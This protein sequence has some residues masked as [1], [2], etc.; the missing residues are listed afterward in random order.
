MKK[1]FYLFFIL[2]LINTSIFAQLKYSFSAST[3]TYT[4]LTEW[5]TFTWAAGTSLDENYTTPTPIGFTFVYNGVPFDSFQVSTNGFLRLGTGLTSAT[6][7]NAL[8]GTLRNVIA[9]LWDDQAVADSLGNITYYVSGTAPNRVL[10]V[11]WS[12]MKWNYNAPAANANY[13]VKLYETTGEIEFIYG[14]FGTPNSGT[15]SIGIN[16]GTPITTTNQATGTYISV[17]VGGVAGA[18]VYHLSM[19]YEFSGVGVPMD[20]NTVLKFSPM[21]ATTPIA[22]GTYTVGGSSPDFPTLSLAAMALNQRGIS[23]PVVLNV[24]SGEYDDIFHLI[25]VAGTSPTNTITL[26]PESGTVTLS[27][28]NG[29]ISSTAPTTTA[30]DAVIRLDGTQFVTIDGINI[31]DNSANTTTVT[32]FEMGILLANSIVTT[33]AGS[34]IRGARFNVLKNLNIDM[35]GATPVVNVGATGIRY[36]TNGTS[37]D[38]S[39]ANSYNVIQDVNIS[40][41]FRSAIRMFGFSGANPDRGNIITATT[42]RNTIGNFTVSSSASDTRQIEIDCQFNFTIE[43]TDIVNVINN[44]ATTQNVYGIWLNPAAS[45][46]NF[47]GGTLMFRDIRIS[48]L[49]NAATGV[50]TG[51]TIGLQINNVATNTVINISNLNIYDLFTNGSSTATCR[52]IVLAVGTNPGTIAN[53]YNNFISDLRAP[54]ST[55]SPS[56]RGLDLQQVIRFNVY[57]N[58]IYLDGTVTATTHQSSGVYLANVSS[59]TIDLRNNIVV[60]VMGT[61]TRAVALY[62]TSTAN[63]QRLA[64]T[65]NNNLYFAGTPGTTRLI[66]YD[67]T[68][69]YQTLAAYRTGLGGGRELNSV[70]ENPPFVNVTT[71]PYD[72]HIS[73]TTPT[74]IESGGQAIAG[75][76]VDFDGDVRNPNFPDI[77][78]DEFSGIAIDENPPLIVY[79]PLGNDR[80]PVSRTLTVT[81]LDASGIP[82][83]A[84]AP[85]LYYKKSTQT[86]FVY[87]DQPVVSGNNY[88]FTFTYANIGGVSE[89]DTIQYYV[90]AQDNAGNVGTNPFGGS[91]VNPP[92]TTPPPTLNW[93]V[94][95]PPPLSGDYIVGTNIF[96]KVT[97][98]NIY[99]EKKVEKVFEEVWVEEPLPINNYEKGQEP[100]PDET[101]TSFRP[102]GRF[103]LREVEK[104]TYIPM[105]NGRSYEGNLYIK[106]YENPDL[107]IPAGVEGIYATLTAAIHDLNL[108]GVSGPTRFLLVD[109]LYSTGE[110]FP[111]IVNVSIDR[112]TA[113]S[114]VTIRPQTGVVSR[115]SGSVASGS[116]LRIFTDYLIVDGSNSGG[117][118]RSL[119]LENTST[120]S[121]SVVLIGSTGTTP[122]TNVTLRNCVIINGANTATAVIISDGATAGNPGYFSN[123][124]ITNNDIRRSYIGIYAIADPT[125]PNNGNDLVISNNRMFEAGTMSIRLV[126]VYVQGVSGAMVSNNT[127]GNFG[128]ADA[129][130][131]ISGIWFAASTVNSTISNNTIGPIV[132]TTTSVGVGRGIAI[133]SGVPN[134]N[135]NILDNDI[136]NI[137]ANYTSP[138]YGI[139][140]FGT[141]GNVVIARNKITGIQNIHTSG[142]GARALH[143]LTN[144]TSSNILIHN[145]FV[146]DVKAT[147]DNS[148]TYWGLGIGIE[149]TTGGVGVYY[150]SV[151]LF[152]TLA[153]YN[154]TSGT[155]H[156][157]MALIGATLTNIDIRNNI[158]VNSFDNTTTTNDKSYAI[159]SQS[160]ATAFAEINHNN[161]FASGP[162]GILGFLGV[163]RP[164]IADWRTATGRDLNSIS[165]S[166]PFVSDTD[167]HI[168]DGTTTYL[169]AGGTP[170]TGITTD[171]DGQIRNAL[172]PDIGAD[173]FNG[174]NPDQTIGWCNLQ[175]PGS[176]SI[177]VGDSVLIFAQIWV[178]G[179]TPG[180]GPGAGIQAW[181]GYST[182]NTNPATWTNWIPAVYNLDV[183]NNDEY[184][185]WLGKNLPVGTYYYASRFSRN[186]GPYYYG[187]YSQSGGGFWDGVNYVSGVLTVTQQPGLSGDYYIPQGSNPKGFPTLDSAFRALNLLGAIGPVRFLIDDNL[188]EI[189]ANLVLNRGDLTAATP[190]TIKPA[191]GKTPV[192]TITGCA[193]ATGPN[194]YGGITING[195]SHVTIDGSNTHGGTTRDL[196]IAM[197]DATNGRIPINV[198]GNADTLAFK[199]LIIKYLVTSNTY[200]TTRGIYFNGQA[201]GVTDS[202]LIENCVIGDS[203]YVPAYAISVTGWSGTQTAASRIYIRNNILYGTL[204][205]VYFFW[206]GAT[207]TYSE[208]NNNMFFAPLPP[209]DGNVRWGILLNNYGGRVDIF[210]NKLQELRMAT[211]GTQ[212]IYGIGTLNNIAGVEVNIYN[213]FLGG[214]FQHT[215]TG[216]PASIDVI[217][218]Q[219]N[220]TLANVFH[221]TIVL[222]DMAKTASGRMTAIRWG[223]TATVNVKNNIIVVLKNASVVYGLYHTSGIVSSDYNAFYIPGDLSNYG[224]YGSARKTLDDW[225]TASGQ[226]I[227]SFVEN[228]PFASALDFH[229][230][231]G[232]VTRI[233]SGGTPIPL[234]SFD[235]DGQPRNPLRPDIGAD[236][237]NGINPNLVQDTV[238]IPFRR[239]WNILSVPVTAQDMTKGNLFPTATSSA[240]WF[241]GQEYVVKDTL[242]VGKGYWLKFAADSSTTVIGSKR[243]S[244]VIP[245]T[246]GWNL[247][248][249]LSVDIPT[250]N[251]YTVPS[252]LLAS[253]FFGFM[254]RY[255]AATTLKKG[256]GYWIKTSGS[257]SLV[258]KRT[259]LTKDGNEE[260]YVENIENNWRRIIISDAQGITQELYLADKF[261]ETKYQLPPLP[262]SSMFDVRFE[263]DRYV[264]LDNYAHKIDL[265]GVKYP[266]TI[267]I[268][269]AEKG[270]YR[271]KDAIDGKTLNALLKNGQPF[272]ITDANIKSIVIEGAT[273]PTSF[274]LMQNYPNPFNPS[275]TIRYA[276]P[277]PVKV[278][279]VV[280]NSV[281]QKVK[282]LVNTEQE[283][284]YYTVDFNASNLASGVYM[285]RLETAK[286]TKTIKALLIK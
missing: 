145:N 140:L 83:G 25:N 79:T 247:I 11:Q 165:V 246:Q 207:G 200:T 211:T 164:T 123:I 105:E 51:S 29:S 263:S 100:I 81:I 237:F 39:H 252:G 76:N 82:T 167:L 69:S 10:T 13:Q 221:N 228:P 70:T 45:T 57:F 12:K 186:N 208:I 238:T 172:T 241:N 20:A 216:T 19:G 9:P 156:A 120:T 85:R 21:G 169:E 197:N 227:N 179:V 181:I 155:I 284:G 230:P 98:K 55:G 157:A 91:G 132:G 144:L 162:A 48:N 273:I 113:T 231:D 18:R 212:G 36:G 236:E 274:D 38:T 279:L 161:Y 233:E 37:T 126:G 61:G 150:N 27:P 194:Q 94:I 253:N 109:T 205:T 192:I 86:S 191:P 68:N 125:V 285:I 47:N 204:R 32:K 111:L 108:R 266:V 62:A 5:N 96:N 193:S 222:N 276:I 106:K 67:G 177:V 93:F 280:Y 257:G 75:F 44:G 267:T 196:T 277:E 131:N 71:K 171:I 215:G 28:R 254:N 107:N 52:G 201:S 90:A 114:T 245:V 163:D 258:L 112:P 213:N 24:R 136:T 3:G 49:Q 271:I 198:Y 242:E 229:I 41:C 54:R 223:G 282:E 249:T 255:Y 17:N 268:T 22:A 117:T 188:N 116:I 31:V 210:N 265:Q 134:S 260:L 16:D 234:V 99:F 269:N 251:V 135:I 6:L 42:G 33:S 158:F 283:A 214:N 185:A 168:P 35:K 148:A 121:P 160:P 151:N 281:G 122:I 202:V 170:I 139:Y 178:D 124:S 149:G 141:T 130:T 110:T 209:A 34:T 8:W 97:G 174:L 65:T 239:Y 30:G 176:A 159:I 182:T 219:D 154:S 2:A 250:T 133:S 74:R 218:F 53:I 15:A 127:I 46:I 189:G 225:K 142:Y 137:S 7:T 187:G 23:G 129:T 66:A 119:T 190:L 63:L 243:D 87:D 147:A 56:V 206:A 138:P 143:V 180:S 1:Y 217:S 166:A 152:G 80:N 73:T 184:M 4:P 199:N 50:T 235:I 92:G 195:T 64:S 84:N 88:T 77:G 264:E 89:R 272:T 259:A 286:F 173:E 115:I 40:N 175:W 278:K 226:D 232:S 203:I 72:L 118:D 104:I 59:S 256:E 26:K 262:P 95:P 102:N 275:T 240:F 183:G 261:D 78:A 146:S 224:Y 60:N 43:K 14:T 58:T 248:G 128:L 101:E 103:E 244:L 270:L 220:V 153:G